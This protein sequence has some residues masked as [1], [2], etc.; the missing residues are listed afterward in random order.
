MLRQFWSDGVSQTQCS[1][2][3]RHE[4]IYLKST[5]FSNN[6]TPHLFVQFL[7]A[8]L[9]TARHR[10]LM[11]SERTANSNRLALGIVQMNCNR[12]LGRSALCRRIV[13]M[14]ECSSQSDI[15]RWNCGHLDWHCDV[16][17]RSRVRV[18]G[19]LV[20]NRLVSVLTKMYLPRRKS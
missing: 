5:I 18:M 19:K 4:F 10:S 17:A 13:A 15:Q 3:S 14:W 9:H 20:M 11:R 12:T 6:S 16:T 1:L 8:V 2:S 7:F